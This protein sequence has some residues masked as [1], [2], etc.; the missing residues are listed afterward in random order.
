M[1]NCIERI[2]EYLHDQE[3]TSPFFVNIENAE[4]K[5]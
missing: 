3:A 1:S 2:K 5:A 4:Q